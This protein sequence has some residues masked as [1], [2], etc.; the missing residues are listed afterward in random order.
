MLYFS[1]DHHFDHARIIKYTARPFST[2]EE[3][4][5]TLI[6][7]WNERVGPNDTVLYTGDFTLRNGEVAWRFFQQLEGHVLMMCNPQHHDKRWIR[8]PQSTKSG[9]V[10]LVSPLKVIEVPIGQRF[11]LA[12]VICHFP[13]AEWERKS[14]G[15]IH[16]HGHSH[17]KYNSEGRIMDI[18]VDSHDFY[19][20]SINFVLEAFDVKMQEV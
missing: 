20:V 10:K 2:V 16:L 11:P 18:G 3:M 13:I 8:T 5:E 17:G 14:H 4:N 9:P 12:I 19:P 7:R 6:E 1:S 15:S